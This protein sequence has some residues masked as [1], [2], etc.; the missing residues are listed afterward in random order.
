[1]NAHSGNLQRS[2]LFVGIKAS[3]MRTTAKSAL[4]WKRTEMVARK[5]LTWAPAERISFTKGKSSNWQVHKLLVYN[6]NKHPPFPIRTP[7]M[8]FQ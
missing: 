7:Y 4:S 2:V 1:M 6:N 5:S 8:Q 3:Q